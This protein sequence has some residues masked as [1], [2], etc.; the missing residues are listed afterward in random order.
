MQACCKHAGIVQAC[1]TGRHCAGL[2]CRQTVPPLALPKQTIHVGHVCSLVLVR[3]TPAI[4]LSSLNNGLSGWTGTSSAAGRFP[5]IGGMRLAFNPNATDPYKRLVDV[6]LSDV[7][8]SPSVK[9]YTGDI[10]LLTTNYV[11]AGGD[12]CVTSSN[13]MPC[14]AV[15]CKAMPSNTMRCQAVPCNAIQ[16]VAGG[17]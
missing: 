1:N 9:T 17:Q 4:L 15:P 16:C 7:E 10:I 2:Q 3:I 13:A 6:R 5:Q 12:K 14:H 8:G 11:A